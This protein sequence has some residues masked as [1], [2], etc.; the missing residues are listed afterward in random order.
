MRRRTFLLAGLPWFSHPYDDLA[1]VRFRVLSHGR[2]HRHYL[3]I[4]G[5]E[6]TARDVLQAHLKTAKGKAWLTTSP[7]RNVRIAGL[8]IDPNRLWS[9]EGAERNMRRLNTSATETQV[10]DV[11]NRLDRGRDR[12]LHRLLPPAQGL[13][14]VLHNNS[15]GYSVEDEIPISDRTHLPK[16]DEPH[17]FFLASN[18]SDYA[19]LESGPYNAVLQQSP[20]GDDD[21][22]LSRLCARRSIRYVNLEVS[23]GKTSIQAGMLRWLEGTLA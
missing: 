12:F 16:R 1:G 10:Q 17:E 2:S 13:L 9:R 4:H 22:S 21:G 14:I 3:W 8:E 18:S 20:K 7:D 11:L 23:L 15:A 6:T 5:N 19:R